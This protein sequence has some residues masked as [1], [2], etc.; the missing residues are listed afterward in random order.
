MSIIANLV[1]RFTADTSGFEAG[2][3]RAGQSMKSMMSASLS[4]QKA[5]AGLTA[6]YIGGRALVGAIRS[7]TDAA[8]A[9]ESAERKLV[10]ALALTG[11]ATGSNVSWIKE[12]AAALQKETI[13]SDKEILNQVAL[14]KNMGLS[15]TE[16]E[17]A[18]VAAIG[19]AAK[20]DKDLG[21]A[22]KLVTLASKGETGQL[23]E[24][25]IVVGKNL[26]SQE[27]YNELIRQGAA[28]FALAKSATKDAAGA[29]AQLANSWEDIKEIIGDVPLQMLEQFAAD[30]AKVLAAI[31][32]EL[33]KLL[34]VKKQFDSL[35]PQMQQSVTQAYE[36]QTGNKFGYY[37]MPAWSMPGVMTSQTQRQFVE[38]TDGGYAQR[39]LDDAYSRSSGRST[40]GLGTDGA[41]AITPDMAA[42]REQILKLNDDLRTQI[43]IQHELAAG[44]KH[45][46][47][48][49]RLKTEVEKAFAEGS[50]E[51]TAA[52]T[53]YGSAMEYL[54]NLKARAAAGDLVKSME[55]ENEYL[56]LLREGRE[57]E[58]EALRVVNGL[59][60]EGIDLLPEETQRIEE[61]IEANEKLQK[62]YGNDIGGG[63]SGAVSAM[64]DDLGGLGDL[65]FDVV[66]EG[67]DG[68]ADAMTNALFEAEDLGQA[69]E[70]LAV[71]IAKMVAQWAIK[72]AITSALGG[73][74]FGGGSAKGNVFGPSGLVPFAR[75]GVVDRPTLFPFARGTG[76]MGEAGPEGI[77]P[78]KRTAGGELGVRAEL[79]SSGGGRVEALLGRIVTLLG[80]RQQVNLNATIADGRDV[81]TR[82]Q[83]ESR[84]GERMVMYH[85]G[86]NS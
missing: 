15:T 75:G 51:A 78:L 77:L 34:T 71:D 39:L 20:Y 65:S 48:T 6:A 1:A 26:T 73:I 5:A 33:D 30:A 24:M 57:E 36:S 49:V 29:A 58:A 74:E 19:L 11:D 13:Y 64:Q 7:V 82:R 14:A 22:M 23:K 85:V 25:G 43:E 21:Q 9:Q 46:A 8:M 86:R 41:A 80:Q 53:K 17:R 12:Y 66:T 27:K 32:A 54:D 31:K 42:A 55:E 76:L 63:I 40:A 79:G 16:I 60:R 59:R 3:K 28:G 61:L 37:D 67:I 35:S 10:A 44:N 2:T 4:L 62:G 38:P 70:D 56:S 72:S 45:A 18:T 81:V 69:M 47:E 68:L 83:M 84:E 50:A 52:M